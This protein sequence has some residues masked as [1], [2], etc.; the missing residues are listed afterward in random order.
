MNILMTFDIDEAILLSKRVEPICNA[1][2]SANNLILMQPSQVW[3]SLFFLKLTSWVEN[4]AVLSVVNQQLALRHMPW[5]FQP[6]LYF[7]SF[8]PSSLSH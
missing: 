7:L 8:C 2:R 5:C 4:G 1:I 6:G 3:V